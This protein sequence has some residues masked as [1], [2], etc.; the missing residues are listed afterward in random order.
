M[1]EET[2]R[3][4]EEANQA[5]ING[6]YAT[7]RPLLEQAIAACPDAGICHWA[8]GHVLLNVGEFELSIERFERAVELEP[9]CQRFLLDLAKTLEMLGEYERAKPLLE[10]I[11]QA[12]PSTREAEDAR[13]SLQYY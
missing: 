8:M 12:D 13:K 4:F 11:I 2:K 10:R 7:A 6:D 1:D 9:D 3:L 5:R